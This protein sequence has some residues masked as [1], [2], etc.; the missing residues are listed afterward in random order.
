MLSVACKL[1]LVALALSAVGVRAQ[2]TAIVLSGLWNAV[3]SIPVCNA[4]EQGTIHFTHA[5]GAYSFSLE[6]SNRIDDNCKNAGPTSCAAAG[7]YLSAQDLLSTSQMQALLSLVA[8]CDAG[9]GPRGSI[10]SVSFASPDS[11]SGTAISGG[12]RDYS[13]Q[14]TRAASTSTSYALAVTKS[15]TGSGTVSSSPAGIDCGATCSGTFSSGTKVALTATPASGSTFAGWSGA[16]TGT[17]T[18]TVSMDAAKSVTATFKIAPFTALTTKI[19]TG[20]RATITTRIT[21]N[22]PDVGK[23]GAVF[24]TAWVHANALGT[25]GISAALNSRPSVTSAR[26]N[27]K[28]AGAANPLQ[29]M[30]EALAATDPNAFVLVQLTSSGWQL[31]S[32]GQLVP[33]TSGVLGDQLAAQTI[34]N[35]TDTTNLQGAQFCLGY[36]TSA[37]DMIA[38]GNVQVVA[39]IPDP[40][41]TTAATGSCLLTSMP[42]YRFFNNNAGGHFYTIDA[43]EKNTVIQNYNW[44]RYEGTGFGASI[45]AL[46]GMLPVYRFFNNNA[47][48]HFYTIDEAEKDAVIQNY[49]WFRYEGIG[50][51]ASPVA[52]PGTLPLYR[53]FNNTAGGHFY[54]IDEAEK[55]T[56][57]QN[58]NW[59]RYEGIGFYAYPA[60]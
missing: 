26:D 20:T 11:A 46:S 28:L 38:A 34:L 6:M 14:M 53:F 16:C 21:F 47:G 49:N 25:L 42:V 54:T 19:T 35:D 27:P 8:D 39:V 40:N 15:G 1:L 2:T 18:C 4:T 37:A 23:V 50:F 48:G 41:L 55:D 22:T 13:F 56:V 43:A 51:Y 31:V 29:V 5:N 32:N 10:E 3:I 59:F 12:G 33:Y 58:Y 45:V 52:Q 44:F 57:I 60:P 36:G 30:Q 7:V 17:G 9:A 24:V